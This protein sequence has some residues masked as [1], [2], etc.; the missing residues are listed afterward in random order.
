[1]IP[2]RRRDRF[3]CIPGLTVLGMPVEYLSVEQEARY[4][5]FA[6]EPTPGELEQFFRLDAGAATEDLPDHRDALCDLRL[7]K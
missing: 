5:R 1:L 2:V 6:A 4:G 7:I 3:A